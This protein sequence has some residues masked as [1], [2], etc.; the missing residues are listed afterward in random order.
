MEGRNEKNMPNKSCNCMAGA[1][2]KY[3]SPYCESAKDTTG[4]LCGC[5]HAG[6]VGKTA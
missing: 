3:C 4:I 2:G 1:D 5:K 6:C